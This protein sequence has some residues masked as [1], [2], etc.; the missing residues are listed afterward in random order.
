MY[1]AYAP[2]MLFDTRMTTLTPWPTA[3]ANVRDP[4]G[5]L[6][7]THLLVGGPTDPTGELFAGA[8]RLPTL[9]RV[10]WGHAEVALHPL[11]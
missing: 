9:A 3:G 2:T 7:V 6:G 8:G 1:G 11:H 5:R 4:V 10:R